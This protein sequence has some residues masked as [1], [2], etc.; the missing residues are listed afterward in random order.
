MFIT[1]AINPVEMKAQDKHQ[2]FQHLLATGVVLDAAAGAVFSASHRRPPAGDSGG[3]RSNKYE[4]PVPAL[5]HASGA[6]YVKHG[7]EGHG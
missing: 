4:I 1:F 3:S 2:Q 6:L 7:Q 5:T